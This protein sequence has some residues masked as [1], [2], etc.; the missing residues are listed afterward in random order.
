MDKEKYKKQNNN[1]IK[2]YQLFI[3]YGQLSF[4]LKHFIENSRI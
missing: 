3:V 2:A 4:A 1:L